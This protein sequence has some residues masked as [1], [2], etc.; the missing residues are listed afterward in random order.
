PFEGRLTLRDV[1][2]GETLNVDLTAEDLEAFRK[3]QQDREEA[4]KRFAFSR[5]IRFIAVRSDTPFEEVVLLTLREANW[6]RFGK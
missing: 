5:A 4:L 1:E 3:T 2:T 6:L